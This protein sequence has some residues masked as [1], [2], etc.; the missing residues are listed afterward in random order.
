MN[1]LFKIIIF[2]FWVSILFIFFKYQ[3][4]NNGT[5]K[6]INFLK[7]YPQYSVLLFLIIASLRTITLIP[8]TVFIIIGCLLFSPL[9][10][11]VLATIANLLSEILLFFFTKLTL[12]MNYQNKMIAKYPKIYNVIEKNTVQILALGV[13]SPVV[14]SDVVCFF[15]SLTGISFKKYVLTIFLADTPIILLYTFLGISVKYSIYVFIVT[16]IVILV[17]SYFN[18]KKW[19]NQ[20]SE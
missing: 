2:V 18:F 11:F 9:E 7:I 20:I 4:Y 6:I 17:L 19:N 14:P 16:L 5:Y 3:L 12:S 13:S 15:S 8:C 1:K 10:A